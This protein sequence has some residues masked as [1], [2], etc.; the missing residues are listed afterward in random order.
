MVYFEICMI[1]CSIW[2][3]TDSVQEYN[4]FYSVIILVPIISFIFISFSKAEYLKIMKF[5]KNYEN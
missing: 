4:I 5:D 1:I 2:I 3:F